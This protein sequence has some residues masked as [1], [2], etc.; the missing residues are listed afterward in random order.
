MRYCINSA[1]LI[2]KPASG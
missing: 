2:F 1:A